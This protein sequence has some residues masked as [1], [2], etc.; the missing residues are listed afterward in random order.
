VLLG[1]VIGGIGGFAAGIILNQ[2]VYAGSGAGAAGGGDGIDTV[3]I[4]LAMYGIFFAVFG[5]S[6]GGALA[7]KA[8][9]PGPLPAGKKPGYADELA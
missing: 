4:G 1:A 3:L 7:F 2:W 8:T 9:G 6:L 5:G